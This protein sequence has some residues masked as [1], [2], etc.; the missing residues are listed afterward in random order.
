[1]AIAWLSWLSSWWRPVV[2]QPRQGLTLAQIAFAAKDEAA[3]LRQSKLGDLT[4]NRN[5]AAGWDSLYL[6]LQLRKPGLTAA[7]D[8]E[9]AIEKA[10][11]T[12]LSLSHAD[13][14]AWVDDM[15]RFM[16]A[17]FNASQADKP[18]ASAIAE[19][20]D[21]AVEADDADANADE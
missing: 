6:H 7:A 20:T 12:M 14:E 17:L 3:R 5:L 19:D 13:A 1:M 4:K 21:N 10:T 16:L 15:G 18:V 8:L 9:V 2:D 11:L